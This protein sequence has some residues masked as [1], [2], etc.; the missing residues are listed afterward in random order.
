[1]TTLKDIREHMLNYMSADIEDNGEIY[2][3][4]GHCGDG[5]WCSIKEFWRNFKTDKDLLFVVS[6]EYMSDDIDLD[7]G[8]S[9]IL[10]HSKV[11][12]LL[13]DYLYSTMGYSLEQYQD[14][15][16]NSLDITD[17]IEELYDSPD[18]I[19]DAKIGKVLSPQAEFPPVVLKYP[20][21]LKDVCDKDENL[22]FI[23]YSKIDQCPIYKAKI[24]GGCE[25]VLSMQ[26]AIAKNIR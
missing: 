19:R 23:G 10:T 20:K 5:M 14:I 15:I 25:V 16:Y 9:Y 8:R 18:V 24:T 7:G 1:M 21:E 11:I 26:D 2:D 4:D 22:E 3:E 17:E 6:G 13:F 12:P